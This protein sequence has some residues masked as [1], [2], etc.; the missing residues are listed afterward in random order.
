MATKNT[1]NKTCQ[2]QLPEY[3]VFSLYLLENLVGPEDNPARYILED[4]F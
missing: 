4:V 2:F 3:T 1:E